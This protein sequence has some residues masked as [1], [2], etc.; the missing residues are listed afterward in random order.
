MSPVKRHF[1]R[2]LTI[3]L[4]LT[5][6]ISVLPGFARAEDAAEQAVSC[7]KEFPFVEEI[8]QDGNC[9]LRIRIAAAQDSDALI[10]TALALFMQAI[11]KLTA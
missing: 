11:A 7:L 4:A 5:L 3:F 2:T 1:S 6:L 9:A 8:L 10:T